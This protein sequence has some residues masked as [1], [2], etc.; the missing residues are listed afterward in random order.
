MAQPQV[1]AGSPAMPVPAYGGYYT[2]GRGDHSDPVVERI[3][4]E[5]V[6]VFVHVHAVGG[7][8]GGVERG[9]FITLESG[10]AGASHG[11]DG[12]GDEVDFSDAM[13]AGVGNVEVVVV[14]EGESEGGVEGG[15]GRCVDLR[16]PRSPGW[17]VPAKV[18]MTFDFRYRS[19]E[20]GEPALSAT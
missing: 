2:V 1:A 14:V 3:G 13:V 12:F 7:M 4:D 10:A 15:R 9:A 8:E 17:P 6:S 5:D 11:G 20:F 16:L 18:E 19:C